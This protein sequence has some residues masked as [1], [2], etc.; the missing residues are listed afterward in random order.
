V[1]FDHLAFQLTVNCEV[2]RMSS[3]ESTLK[4]K[5]IVSKLS[6]TDCDIIKYRDITDIILGEI[7]LPVDALLC[8]NVNCSRYMTA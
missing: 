8:R 5:P 1:V 3:D 4:L 2:V 7:C 6:L